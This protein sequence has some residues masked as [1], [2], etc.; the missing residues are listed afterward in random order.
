ML[1]LRCLWLGNSGFFPL[2]TAVWTV[3]YSSIKGA[4]VYS[5]HKRSHNENADVYM[6]ALIKKASRRRAGD[7]FHGKK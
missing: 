1:S 4:I 3:D 7:G 6:Q 5:L 2:K